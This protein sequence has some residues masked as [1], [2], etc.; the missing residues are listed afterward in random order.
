M[1][2]VIALSIMA[3]AL[4]VGCQTGQSAILTVPVARDYGDLP[5]V[6]VAQAE[7]AVRAAQAACGQVSAPY[8]FFSAVFYLEAAR[9]LS[10]RGARD[11]AGLAKAMAETAQRAGV[12]SGHAPGDIAVGDFS[13]LKAEYHSLDKS[14]ASAVAPQLYAHMTAM[15]SRAEREL[16]TGGAGHRGAGYMAM[17]KADMAALALQDSDADGVPDLEDGA[18][19]APEDMDHFQDED[20]APD[21]DNDKDGVPDAVDLAPDEPE[22]LNRYQDKDGAPDEYPALQ[23]VSFARGSDRLSTEAAAYLLGM[24]HFIKDWPNVRLRLSGH[25]HP[26]ESET[27]AL[28]LSRARAEAVKAKLI[29]YGVPEAQLTTT[30]FGAAAPETGADSA[31][32]D[33]ALE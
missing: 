32:V 4:L 22:T 3:G 29:E 19:W 24:T 20:G 12:A 18:P 11:Y 21:P 2:R 9:E 7:E 33:L 10:G 14:R 5:S 27:R 28:E 23:S 26:Q 16:E 6:S 25:C 1:L 17:V 15:L 31:R 13:T 30:F 8:D